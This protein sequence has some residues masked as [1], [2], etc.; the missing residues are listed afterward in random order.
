MSCSI[1]NL[2]AKCEIL[3]VLD[4]FIYTIKYEFYFK[5][6][7]ILNEIKNIE[8]ALSKRAIYWWFSRLVT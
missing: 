8:L 4:A 5:Q 2:C 1:I 7:N 3:F 6:S